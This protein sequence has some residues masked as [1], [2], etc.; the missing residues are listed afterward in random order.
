MSATAALRAVDA[1]VD[2]FTTATT[3]LAVDCLVSDGYGVSDEGYDY[4]LNVG[5][6]DP[7]DQDAAA[8]VTSEQEWAHANTLTRD[9]TGTVRCALT[10]ST[11]DSNLAQPR[12]DAEVILD[13]CSDWLRANVALGLPDVFWAAAV[14]EVEVYQQQDDRGAFVQ[15]VF[16]VSYKARLT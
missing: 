2:G 8:S 1:L 16:S 14:T 3:G 11:G 4:V 9:E 12:A 15:V 7:D 13:A 5:V 10:L 6:I